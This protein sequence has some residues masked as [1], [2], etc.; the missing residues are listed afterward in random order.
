M[1]RVIT[2]MVVTVSL[3]SF[4]TLIENLSAQVIVEQPVIEEPVIEPTYVAVPPPLQEV[5]TTAPS[6]QYVWVNGYWDRTPDDWDWMPGT[7]VKP[8]YQNAYWVPG[9]WQNQGGTYQWE[10]AHWALADQGYVVQK[11]IAVPPLYEEVQPAAPAGGTNLTWQPGYWQWRGT[12][13]WMPG[14]YVATT[15]TD[16][17]WVQGQ[18]V[19]GV[20]GTWNWSPAH[21][22]SL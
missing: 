3:Y 10:D 17:T 14:A 16:A 6:P 5:I 15:T 18:W 20:D 13:V 1:R 12:W 7:W 21:W 11:P 19:A 22:A 2:V 8:P 4:G 9:Y